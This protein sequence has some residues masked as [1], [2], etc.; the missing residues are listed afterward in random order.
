M[1]G[2]DENPPEWRIVFQSCF[3]PFRSACFRLRG[4]PDLG[5]SSGPS[6]RPER[7][8]SSAT[9]PDFNGLSRMRGNEAPDSGNARSGRNDE[10]RECRSEKKGNVGRNDSDSIAP[11]YSRAGLVL[12]SAT[13]R[14]LSSRRS[15]F[16]AERHVPR[17]SIKKVDSVASGNFLTGTCSVD[18]ESRWPN[19]EPSPSR[20]FFLFAPTRASDL[21]APSINHGLVSKSANPLPSFRPEL[22]L[23]PESRL[24]ARFPGNKSGRNEN[25]P[26]STVQAPQSRNK[27]RRKFHAENRMVF[28]A[29][30]TIRV[31]WP[32]KIRQPNGGTFEGRNLTFLFRSL[33]Q[34][35]RLKEIPMRPREDCPSLKVFRNW[36]SRKMRDIWAGLWSMK[37]PF[38]EGPESALVI[39]QLRL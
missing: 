27:F 11:R 1:P 24:W 36:K 30:A 26:H 9:P 2:S 6:F 17:V 28:I 19:L 29:P 32:T 21:R 39:L 38:Q 20:V 12:T 8:L 18:P 16:R 33:S 25:Q 14:G 34:P 5:F 23:E 15:S 4:S 22:A 35:N 31:Q 7:A 10:A 13:F 3:V 37:V